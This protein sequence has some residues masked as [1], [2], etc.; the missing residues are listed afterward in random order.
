MIYLP[1]SSPETWDNVLVGELG[2]VLACTPGWWNRRVSVS[3]CL[4][5]VVEWEWHGGNKKGLVQLKACG[6]V[7]AVRDGGGQQNSVKPI[8]S[9]S[10][11]KIVLNQWNIGKPN[12]STICH[13]IPKKTYSLIFCL[14]TSF[15]TQ[16]AL[17]LLLDGVTALEIAV[18]FFVH[19]QVSLQHG[20]ALQG[21]VYESTTNIFIIHALNTT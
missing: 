18:K 4:F 13:L 3:W 10:L 2:L 16:L 1:S 14:T 9:L 12:H 15:S 5:P 20:T 17:Q 6:T 21:E 7:N 11:L 8:I 19:L